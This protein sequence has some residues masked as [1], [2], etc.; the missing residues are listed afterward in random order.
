[1]VTARV[2]FDGTQGISVNWRTRMRDQERGRIAADL[3]RRSLSQQLHQKPTARDPLTRET[4]TS[5][6]KSFLTRTSM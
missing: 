2:L 1:M 4:G 3:E 5:W 6:A